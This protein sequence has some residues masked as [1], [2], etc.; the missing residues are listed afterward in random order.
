MSHCESEEEVENT[1]K[2]M[3]NSYHLHDDK[4]FNSMYKIRRKWAT[5]FSNKLFS[6]GLLATSR[7]ESANKVLKQS[8]SKSSSLY[9]FVMNYEKVQHQWRTKEK[10]EDTRCR[11]GKPSQI[12]KNN[13][14]LN[15]VASIYTLTIYGLFEIE[16]VNSLNCKFDGQPFSNGN[17]GSSLEFRVKSYGDSLRIRL[18]ETRCSCH[19]FETMGILCKHVLMVFNYMDVTM[20]PEAYLLKRWMKCARL[21]VFNDFKATNVLCGSGEESDL[22]FVNKVMRAAY[23]LAH[24]S[25]SHLEA[26]NML[27]TML[28]STRDQIVDFIQNLDLEDSSM[29]DDVENDGNELGVRIL[30]PLTAKSRG[31]T[32]VCITR[33]WDRKNKKGKGISK[34]H[35]NASSEK[36]SKRKAQSTQG[37]QSSQTL[38][39]IPRTQVPNMS[40]PQVPNMPLPQFPNIPLPQ[41]PNVPPRPFPFQAPQFSPQSESSQAPWQ[42]P[43]QE[44]DSPRPWPAVTTSAP[45]V[46]PITTSVQSITT[47]RPVTPYCPK[48]PQ[49]LVT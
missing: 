31:L 25:K 36:G 47:W 1:W 19:K 21:R 12:L 34:V 3:I 37:I 15:H 22:V 13:P 8:G 16:L 6:A 33:H 18:D 44:I 30:N 20:I 41:F 17:D 5:V 26:R 11:H 39:S 43:T 23:N 7:S 46:R 42:Y 2:F 35:G 40:P 14:L 49:H 27:T 32:N 28:D 24:M 29:H 48:P 45:P 38:D 10:V 4:W 9:D